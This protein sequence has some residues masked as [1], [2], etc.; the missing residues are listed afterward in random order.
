MNRSIIAVSTAAA[1]ALA[2]GCE[3]KKPTAPAVPA[4]KSPTMPSTPTG[5]TAPSMPAVSVPTGVT[6]AANEAKAKI[7]D[8][9]QSG[10]DSLKTQISTLADKVKAAPMTQQPSLLPSLNEIQ[11]KFTTVSK[12]IAD[13]KGDYNASNW[14]KMADDAKGNLES[15]KASVTTLMDKLK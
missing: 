11:S 15:L 13:L 10:L 12:Q 3:E 14:Q 4:S 6:Q 2:A 8:G 7:A 5:A 1:I 9:L